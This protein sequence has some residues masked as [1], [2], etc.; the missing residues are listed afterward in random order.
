MGP[1]MPSLFDITWQFQTSLLQEIPINVAQVENAVKNE[2]IKWSTSSF[3]R[4]WELHITIT[5]NHSF[6]RYFPKY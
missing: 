2:N 3:Y 1:Q 5:L 6:D 4:L